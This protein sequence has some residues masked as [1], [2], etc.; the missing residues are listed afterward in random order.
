MV[1]RSRPPTGRT[2][3]VRSVSGRTYQIG[4][5][6]ELVKLSLRTLRYYEEVGL[7][8]PS[9][10]SPGGFRLYNDADL[11]RLTFIKQLRPLEFTLEQI[12]DLLEIRDRLE[13]SSDGLV[14][15][16]LAERLQVFI[17]AA[18]DRSRVLAEQAQGAEVLA[19]SLQRLLRKAKSPATA[20]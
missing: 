1:A 5:A 11:Q 2:E 7:V 18:H 15:L 20:R 13:Q 12:R 19:T 16:E 9:G 6:A 14:A 10:R 3:E 4:E 17:R 8:P